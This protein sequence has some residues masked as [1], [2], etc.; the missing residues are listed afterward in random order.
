MDEIR[1]LL[2]DILASQSRL[3]RGQHTTI[4]ALRE[5]LLQ[6]QNMSKMH[7]DIMAALSANDSTAS[8]VTGQITELVALK[9]ESDTAFADILTK[10]RA[11]GTELVDLQGKLTA[12][13]AADQPAGP[14]GTTTPVEPPPAGPT[15]DTE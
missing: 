14:T 8:T 13:L 10:V 11:Q 12:A 1:Q 6:G 9:D 2:L 5:L 4:R 3:E 15:G 7:D